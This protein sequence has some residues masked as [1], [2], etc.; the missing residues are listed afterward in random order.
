M[1]LI[2]LDNLKPYYDSDRDDVLNDFYIPVLKE[3]VDY[4][5][6]AGFF[7][8][9]ALAVASRGI[10]GLLNNNAIFLCNNKKGLCCFNIATKTLLYEIKVHDQDTIN[11]TLLTKAK[12]RKNIID[13]LLFATKTHFGVVDIIRGSILYFIPMPRI[14]EIFEFD[15]LIVHTYDGKSHILK[16]D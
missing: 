12:Y 2:D 11:L 1:G 7:S 16:S 10:K 15:D 5:R 14:K 8:S 9:T 6:L 4:W 3:S 13:V